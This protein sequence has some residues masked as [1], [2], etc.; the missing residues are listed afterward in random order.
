MCVVL[1]TLL[2]VTC[3]LASQVRFKVCVCVVCLSGGEKSKCCAYLPVCVYGCT[4]QVCVIEMER[5]LQGCS[6]AYTISW[7]SI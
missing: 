3:L 1:F 6:S 5:V 2:N 4:W 7:T